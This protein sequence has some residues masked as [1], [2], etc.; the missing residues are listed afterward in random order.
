MKEELLAQL[1]LEQIDGIGNKVGKLLISYC[2]SAAQVFKEPK[3]KLLKIPGIGQH[4]VNM[5]KETNGISKA[6]EILINTEKIGAKLFHYTHPEYPS[7]LKLIPDAPTFIFKQ[8]NGQNNAPR[9]LAIVGTR[10]ATVYGKSITE[11]IVADCSMLDVQIISGLA[12][13]IDI[14]AH[15][16]ALEHHISTIAVLA[17]GLDRIYPSQH[18]KYAYEM[19]AKGAIISECAP[20]VK[21]DPHLFPAR[22]RIIAGMADAVIIVEAATK[23]GALITANVADSYNRPVFAVPGNL[24][25]TYSEGTNQLIRSQKAL[26]FTSVND[27]IYYLNWDQE[28]QTKHQD[29]MISLEGN[30]KKV[31]E[32]LMKEGTIEIDLLSIKTQI[33]IN[34]IASDLLN[35]EF[36]N[37]VK[38]LPGKKYQAR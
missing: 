31:Y 23:G 8:G 32:I 13:G 9:T 35:L 25:N 15:K 19:Q 28:Q 4:L 37:L 38:S 30:E 27:L 29:T 21:P 6:E 17:G 26:I 3:A 18:K 14:Q 1:A 5:I 22:N 12:Y 16:S 36:K 7:R 20:G 2:G 24:G 34:Q 33:P 11:K 10:K